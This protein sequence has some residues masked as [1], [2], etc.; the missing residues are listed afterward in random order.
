V[1]LL[2]SIPL[3]V[4]VVVA[5]V[6]AVGLGLA[7][8]VRARVN[9]VRRSLQIVQAQ[10]RETIRA[11]PG[12]DAGAGRASGAPDGRR[13][14]LDLELAPEAWERERLLHWITAGQQLVGLVR[15]ALRDHDRLLREAGAAQR[16]CER[17]RCELV[18]LQAECDRLLRE[19]RQFA[20]ALATFVHET[21]PRALLD[22]PPAGLP[23]RDEPGP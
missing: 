5:V 2:N 6:A 16:E 8:A 20:Q 19:R 10:L 11:A 4:W 3:G 22:A 12:A 7:L 21:G 14:T 18:R 17:L 9:G 13:D 1:G 23:P 15:S